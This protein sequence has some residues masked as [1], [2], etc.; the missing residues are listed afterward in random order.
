MT[1]DEKLA[2]LEKFRGT[3]AT[4]SI[5]ADGVGT[6]RNSI[7]GFVRRNKQLSGI[8][9][10][11]NN[12]GGERPAK[13]PS[14][15]E[16]RL[17]R[18]ALNRRRRAKRVAQLAAEGKM[19]PRP[20]AK[21]TPPRRKSVTPKVTEAPTTVGETI[22]RMATPDTDVFEDSAPHDTYVAPSGTW[23]PIPGIEPADLMSRTGCCW[24]LDVPGATSRLYCNATV[25]EGARL[26]Y[27]AHHMRHFTGKPPK[28]VSMGKK[29]GVGLKYGLKVKRDTKAKG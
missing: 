23:D 7:I 22:E 25:V 5:I 24:P 15:A 19:P 28:G 6:T 10:G 16:I 21:P 12:H 4:A 11:T 29:P 27:C 13:Q 3:N 14:N 9:C 2:A 8:L 18:D 1:K 26:D 20:K 17:R